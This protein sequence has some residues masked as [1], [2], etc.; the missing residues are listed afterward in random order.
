MRYARIRDVRTS[1]A[2]IPFPTAN[3]VL[4]ALLVALT[5]ANA[6]VFGAE[7]KIGAHTFTVPDGFT[8]ESALPNSELAPRPVSAGFDDQGAL[9]VSDSSG[10]S[11]PPKEQW[12]DPQNRILKL[13]DADGDG[14]YEKQT[15]FADKIGFIQGCLW[16]E[17]SVYAAAPPSLWK[18][19]D[20]D[21]DGVAEKREE[22]FKQGVVTHCGNDIHGPY[23]GLDGFLYWTKGAFERLN[24]TNALGRP[25]QDKAVHIFRM[26]PDHTGLES[27]MSGGMDNPVEVDFTPSG[28]AIFTSTFMDFSRPGTRDGLGHASYGSVFGKINSVNDDVPRTGDIFLPMTHFGPGA[29]SGLCRYQSDVFGEDHRDNLFASSFNLHK[30]TRH[31]L[32]PEGATFRTVDHDFVVSDSLDFHPTDVLEDADGSLLIVDTGGWYKLCCPSSQLAKVDVLGGIYRVRK[33]GAKSV[34]DPRGLTLKWSGL[35]AGVLARRLEDP[36]PAVRQRSIEML[37]RMGTN[38]IPA[39]DALTLK[40]KSAQA[41]QS[42]LWAL[43]R[44]P[45][46]RAREAVRQGINDADSSV[47]QTAIKIVS[48]WRDP[49]SVV[50]LT[51]VLEKG[52]P[53]LSAVASEALG[54]IANREAIPAILKAAERLP[55]NEIPDKTPDQVHTSAARYLEHSLTYA[56]IELADPVQTSQ[57]LLSNHPG[58]RRISL[59]A[60]DQMDKGGLK[61]ETIATLLRSS[62]PVLQ[63][64]AAAIASRHADWGGALAGFFQDELVRPMTA[65]AGSALAHQIALFARGGPVQEMLASHLRSP[66]STSDSKAIALK[67][68]TQAG[69]S[70]TPSSW[71]AALEDSLKATEDSVLRL[72]VQTARALPTPKAATQDWIEALTR[73]AENSNAATELRLNA[74][75]AIPPGATLS[76]AV[77]DLV[78]AALDPAQSVAHHSAAVT[79]LTRAKLTENQ[80]PGIVEALKNAGPLETTRLLPVFDTQS[81]EALGLNL[82]AALKASKSSSVLRPDLLK[83]RLAKFPDSV[84]TAGDELLASLNTDSDKQRAHLDA[85][86]AGVDKG[87]VRRGQLIFNSPK[88]ACAACH[89]IGYLGGN[90][91]P[92]LTRI[93]DVRSA[94]DLLEAIVYPSAS[95]VRSYEPMVVATT[96]GEE[97][98]GV[99]R[100]DAADELILATGP[101]SEQ[102]I[103]RSTVAEL[104]PGTISIM[105]QGLDQQLSQQELADLIAFLRNTKWGAN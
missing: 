54:R 18:F 88:A 45:G 51:T 5:L 26:R 6:P 70:E 48:L 69:V 93:S 28:E 83:P 38:A 14:K 47:R 40:S 19:T 104:R 65:E 35:G 1:S 23:A 43:S 8:I 82:I 50:R 34:E 13:I 68:M 2:S 4:T 101:D 102:R 84:K 27:I 75:A 31:Q 64:T 77:F 87:D 39:L 62:N 52:D 11:Q 37:G 33:T 81:N 60:L 46:N 100:K 94:R 79:S 24:L 66:Q 72:A 105:P 89:K 57:G 10:S 41:R 85:L 49:K 58:V 25:I 15:V 98:T 91:G 73:I 7:F 30:I 22:W 63:Q 9:Y 16:F 97:Y 21:G 78:L 71:I 86:L 67:A 103:P 99:L 12:K 20:A 29:P 55:R 76:Q 36:R 3:S 92:D 61:P 96:S 80:Y 42:A 90:V 53:A 56:L 59:I 95:F 44:I 17:G 74:A 32:K